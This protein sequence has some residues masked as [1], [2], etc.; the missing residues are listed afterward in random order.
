MIQVGGMGRK[1]KVHEAVPSPDGDSFFFWRRDSAF[2]G[3]FG[4]KKRGGSSP[5]RTQTYNP[6]THASPVNFDPAVEYDGST[7][8][9]IPTSDTVSL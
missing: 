7:V 9:D 1:V 6:H 3:H 5:R 8:F 2:W 4:V